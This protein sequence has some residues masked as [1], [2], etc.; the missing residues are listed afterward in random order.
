MWK[1]LRVTHEW[2]Y[3]VKRVKKNSLIQK[4]EIFRMQQSETIYDVQQ[5]FQYFLS[6]FKFFYLFLSSSN[7]TL[8]D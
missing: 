3:D 6:H 4:Y 1:V 5:I 8:K 2:I 7:F